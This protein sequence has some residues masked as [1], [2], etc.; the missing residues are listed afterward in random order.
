MDDGILH[1]PGQTY[2][3]GTVVDYES[4]YLSQDR[5]TQLSYLRRIHLKP[6]QFAQLV[7]AIQTDAGIEPDQFPGVEEPP[8]QS[9]PD[10]KRGRDQ[11]EE[12][13][14]DQD[15]IQINAADHGGHI[16]ITE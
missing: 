8:K 6:W 13:G 10:K 5:E 2:P 15:L 12:E 9:N 14:K 3:S 7:Q 11:E 16:D 4:T 1:P